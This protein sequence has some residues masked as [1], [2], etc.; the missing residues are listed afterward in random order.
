MVL[1]FKVELFPLI[2]LGQILLG[3]LLFLFPPNSLNLS[4]SNSY[5]IVNSTGAVRTMGTKL[6]RDSG[7][8]SVRR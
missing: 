3:L 7:K 1:K 8:A 2:F 6:S 5:L 4:P